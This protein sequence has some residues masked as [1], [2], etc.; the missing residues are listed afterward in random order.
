LFTIKPD[1]LVVSA[2]K[3]AEKDDALIIRLYNISDK[4]VMGNLAA[5]TSLKGV[6]K[7]NLLEETLEEIAYSEDSF[8][9]NARGYEILTL[10]LKLD[11]LS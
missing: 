2:V 8:S 3:K 9:F 6:W 11:K 4:Q 10:K 5:F 1:E 7:V